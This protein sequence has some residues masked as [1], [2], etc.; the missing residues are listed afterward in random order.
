MTLPKA[1]LSSVK[2][3]RAHADL[4]LASASP[5]RLDLL[6]SVLIEPTTILPADIDETP[7]NRER[8]Q[9]YALRMAIEKCLAT[10]HQENHF[11][12]AADTVV[13]CGHR[14]LPKAETR[15][16]AAYCLDLLSG[17]RHRVWGGICIRTPKE[18]LIPRVVSTIVK[19]KTLTKIEKEIYLESNEWDG[20]AGGYAIQGLA[21]SYVP[22]IS[23]SYSNI[24]GLSLSDTLALLDGNGFFTS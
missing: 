19:F 18:K 2:N 14:I 17:R 8:P 3:K 9:D 10:S 22:F 20:K 6:R 23:G 12:L 4:I 1:A 13:A 24:V 16:D 15:E 5:R 7:R 21:A 11:T